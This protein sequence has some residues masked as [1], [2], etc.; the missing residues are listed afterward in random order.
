[1][2]EEKR[3]SWTTGGASRALG[4]F[5]VDTEP[6][7]EVEILTAGEG[8]DPVTSNKVGQLRIWDW[9]SA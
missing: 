7:G 3:Q 1:V 4:T 8:W 9:N 5:A 2:V 6:D